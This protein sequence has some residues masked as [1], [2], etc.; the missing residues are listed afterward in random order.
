M[1]TIVNH[2]RYVRLHQTLVLCPFLLR[3][4]CQFTQLFHFT[5]FI[6]ALK[7]FGWFTCIIFKPL[8]LIIIT[9]IQPLGRSGQTPELSQVTG[10]A[11]AC[12]ILGKFLRVVC[13]CFPP[14]LFLIQIQFLICALLINANFSGTQLGHKT[15]AGFIL[16]YTLRRQPKIKNFS[17]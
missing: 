6:F 13:H 5:S 1:S 9:G 14:P 7:P 12:C 2:R 11:L 17:C 3:H 8:F 16:I 15:R 4:F 10:M